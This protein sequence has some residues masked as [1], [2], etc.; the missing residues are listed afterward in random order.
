MFSRYTVHKQRFLKVALIFLFLFQSLALL[1]TWYT[2]ATG[3]E[4][5]IYSSTPLILWVSLIL[6]FTIGIIL[7]VQSRSYLN[8]GHGFVWKIGLLLIFMSY[9]IVLG[10]FIIRGYYM[11]CL[12][13]DP[14]SH[15][16]WIKETL[17]LGHAPHSLIYPITHI[18]LSEIILVTDLDQVF[19]HKIVPLIFDLLCVVFMF[20]LVRT[21]TSNHITTVLATVISCTLTYG[22]YL[23]LTPN[24]LSNMFLPFAFFLAFQFLKKNKISWGLLLVTVIILYPAF[25]P[26]PAIFLGLLLLTIWLPLKFLDCLHAS[27]E[28]RNKFLNISISDFRLLMPIL[29]LITCFIFWISSFSAWDYTIKSM[30]QTIISEDSSS[31]AMDLVDQISY[32]QGYGYSVVEQFLKQLGGPMILLILSALSF[33]LLW[34]TILDNRKEKYIFSL[35]GPLGLLCILIPALYLFNLSFGPLR[36]VIYAS[37]LGTVFAAY[38]LSYHLLKN[39]NRTNSVKSRS[40]TIFSVVLVVGLFLLGLLNLY[41]SPYNLTQSYQT[42]QTE[43]QGMEYFYEYR[44]V[45]IPVSRIS[46]A[47]GRFADALLTPEEKSVQDLSLYPKEREIVP[48]HFGY[49][50]H[51]LISNSYNKETNLIIIQKDKVIYRDYFPDMA[52]YRFTA[53]DFERLNYDPGVN[54]L[55][56]NGGFDL[57]GITS[58]RL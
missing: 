8:L 51:P 21:V 47:P 36:L 38:F 24:G 20:L 19:L 33:P 56:S 34:K 22:W 52:R 3:Y 39:R 9:S 28:K 43:V 49:D 58:G 10:L 5:S 14:A 26:V 11:W 55:Y 46:A 57:L 12:G 35:Y 30:Y 18:Y 2:P 31:K 32:A 15:V 41:P 50:V 1:I 44:D 40:V 25:H 54:Y 48:W 16:G 42:T 53:S 13:G 29:I 27:S 6:S 4:A 23:N 37:M 7:I 17:A 45:N